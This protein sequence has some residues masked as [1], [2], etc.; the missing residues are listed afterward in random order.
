MALEDKETRMQLKQ[1]DS[2]MHPARG[3]G[4]IVQI[5]ERSWQGA[6]T[7]YYVIEMLD[8]PRSTLRV[9]V[10]RADELGLRP[11]LPAD[12]LQTVWEVLGSDSES[13]PD[14]HKARITA[15]TD[16]FAKGGALHIAEVV[17]DLAGWQHENGRLNTAGEQLFR[18]GLRFLAMEVAATRGID[19]ERAEHQVR[20]HL[21]VGPASP[22]IG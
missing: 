21:N 18:K 22:G 10:S 8:Q 6:A 3:A 16:R 19:L 13:L 17:R 14:D 1:G 7:Q 11:T 12:Q 9:P 4:T 15:L 20:S 5:E 2:V